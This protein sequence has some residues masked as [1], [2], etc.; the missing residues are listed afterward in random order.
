MS[1]SVP[2]HHLYAAI[3]ALQAEIAAV[4]KQVKQHEEQCAARHHFVS[5]ALHE[6]Q[7]L[8]ITTWQTTHGMSNSPMTE[9]DSGGLPDSS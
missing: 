1:S 4:A 7:N 2:V 6:L 8:T 3:K 5:E 9:A